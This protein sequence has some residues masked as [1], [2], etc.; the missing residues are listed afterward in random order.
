[1]KTDLDSFLASSG[2]KISTHVV[3]VGMSIV[4]VT[5]LAAGFLAYQHQASMVQFRASLIESYR[6]GHDLN[7]L[8]SLIQEAETAERGYLLTGQEHYIGPY[9]QAQ[10]ELPALFDE[11]VKSKAASEQDLVELHKLRDLCAAKLDELSDS[12]ELMRSGHRSEAVSLFQQG[13]GHATFHKIRD[14]AE[15]LKES[16]RQER[17]RRSEE[18]KHYTDVAIRALISLLVFAVASM[19]GCGLLLAL[20]F[21]ARTRLSEQAVIVARQATEATDRLTA[22]LTSMDEGVFSTDTAGSVAFCNGSAE[23]LIGLPQDK[24]VGRPVEEILRGPHQVPLGEILKIDQIVLNRLAV[25]QVALSLQRSAEAD[26]PIRLTA[27][28]LITE[29][30]VTG[31]LFTFFDRSSEEEQLRRSQAQNEI[32]AI[33][34]GA[35]TM[36]ETVGRIIQVICRNF[37]FDTGRVWFFDSEGDSLVCR[38]IF[39]NQNNPPPSFSQPE[40]VRSLQS[41][42]L[43]AELKARKSPVWLANITAAQDNELLPG[44]VA[45]G[46]RTVL[47][48]PILAGEKPLG[49]MEFGCLQSREEDPALSAIFAGISV[50]M[51]QFIER[52]QVQ[53]LLS[54]SERRYSLAVEGTMDGI[55]DWDLKGGRVYW[56]AR[57]MEML[58]YEA[59]E[60]DGSIE[61]FYELV[62]PDDLP[63]VKQAQND[64]LEG[65]TQFYTCQFRLRTKGGEYRW[66]N[67]R[68]IAVRNEIGQPVRLLGTNRDVTNEI[69]ANEKLKQSERKFRAIF[70]KTFEFI[71]LLSVDGRLIDA[72]QSAL[73]FAGGSMSEFYGK[74][75]WECPWW[76]HDPVS[77]ERLKLAIERAAGGEFDRFE[78][79]HHGENGTIYIDFSLQPVE[80]ENGKVTLL[81]PEGRDITAVKEAQEK[82]RESEAMFRR[83][84]E[85]IRSIFWIAAADGSSFIY[86]SPAYELITGGKISEA[87]ENPDNFFHHVYEEDRDIAREAVSGLSS[88]CEFRMLDADGEPNWLSARAFPVHDEK[89]ELIQICG[90]ANDISD[91]KEAE[92]RV[93]EF[94]STVS[95]ELRSP[96]T[97]IRGSLGLIEGGL[98][99]EVSDEARSFVSIARSESERLIRL[100]NSILDLRKIEAGKLD[101]HPSPLNTLEVAQE[102]ISACTGMAQEATVTVEL[103][104]F[105]EATISADID[106]ITQVLTNLIANAIKF[107]A[108]GGCVSLSGVLQDKSYRFSV[109]DHG[110]GISPKDQ[111]RLFG[112]FQQLDSTDSRS[113][114]GSGL[115]LAISK[116][117]V[118]QHGGKIG[119][120]SELGKGSTFWFELPIS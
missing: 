46:A 37:S 53:E 54:L 79:E 45:S 56:S 24:I 81:I 20:L 5:L 100:I 76:I 65:L 98:V 59:N 1:M 89:G 72:N 15:I 62:H 16:Q 43:Q 52:V 77:Q 26:L 27:T 61:K 102:T 50:Q 34:A 94:Y 12:I 107:S 32:S 6:F 60:L 90:V 73:A 55:W 113:K 28:P 8:I 36:Q 4:M 14:A 63:V 116:A 22:V 30:K 13:I 19:L 104:E 69:E 96:L 71:G 57:W 68:G 3:A 114:G 38:F 97:S 29:E 82:L 49:L 7:Q 58:G 48:V 83:L 91:R 41:P 64:H 111:Q 115:G 103:G 9:L 85:N 21:K 18:L 25:R 11:V 33:M 108:A 70:N 118:E 42:V 106:R 105:Q 84:A 88:H 66:F 74:P 117:L 17:D 67:T 10:K 2:T 75:F 40:A 99:G 23:R 112:K 92:K 78:A 101:I 119:V 93:S 44:A 120:Q 31:V 47:T 110:P 39:T 86:L 109:R 80:D 87:I 35:L 51:G 95:H